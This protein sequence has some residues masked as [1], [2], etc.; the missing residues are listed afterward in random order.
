[1]RPLDG[2]E[3]SNT[4]SGSRAMNRAP[5]R[6]D[7]NTSAWNPVGKSSATVSA[8]AEATAMSV[9]SRAVRDP[10]PTQEIVVR[11]TCDNRRR[12]GVQ[13]QDDGTRDQAVPRRAAANARGARAGASGLDRAV[14]VRAGPAGGGLSHVDQV[15]RAWRRL[16]PGRKRLRH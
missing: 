2:M 5:P 13:A 12:H 16:L 7:A 15:G 4:P 10:M 6:P 14:V 9:T 1:T 8:P 3:S 11:P